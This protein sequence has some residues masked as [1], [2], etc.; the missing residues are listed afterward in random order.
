MTDTPLS[1]SEGGAP[2]EKPHPARQ[3]FAPIVLLGLLVLFHLLVNIW[4]LW[5]DNHVI[6]TDEETHMLTARDYYEVLALDEHESVLQLLIALG[7][8]QPRN[9]AHPPL[10]PIMGAALACVFGYGPDVFAFVNTIMFLL[11]ILGCYAVARC[12]LERWGAL[13]AAAVVSFVP[14]VF[15]ASRYFM[16]D[17]PATV[18]V[19]WSLYALLRSD[20]FS[21]RRWVIL[22]AVLNGLGILVRTVTFVYYLVPAAMLVF[23]GLVRALFRPPAGQTRCRA[24]AGLLGNCVATVLIS[25]AVFSPWYFHNLEPLYNFWVIEKPGAEGGPVTLVRESAPESKPQER[26]ADTPVSATAPG[27]SDI[28]AAAPAPKPIEKSGGSQFSYVKWFLHPRVPWVRYPVHVI[29]NNLFVILS[30]LAALGILLFPWVRNYRKLCVL[31]LLCCVLSSYVLMTLLIKYSV[32]RYALPVAPLLGILAALPFLSL[33]SRAV[34][35]AAMIALGVVLLLQFSN[36]TYASLGRLGNYHLPIILD[37]HTQNI[38]DDPGLTVIKDT[39]TYSNSYAELGAAM[40]NDYNPDDDEV[41]VRNCN[42]KERLFLAMVAAEHRRK[43]PVGAYANYIRLGQDMRGMELE[44]RYYWPLPNPFLKRGFPP[45]ELP[46]RKFT[47]IL[48][49][50]TP[51]W[52]LSKLSIADY[53]VYAIPVGQS[54]MER[55]W[56]KFFME[57]GFEPIERFTVRRFGLVYARTYCVMSRQ[58]G[59]VISVDSLDDLDA[60]NRYELYQLQTSVDFHRLPEPM[61]NYAKDR[62]KKLIEEANYPSAVAL[63]EYVT[64]LG[65]DLVRVEEGVFQFWF[66]FK[67]EKPIPEDWRIFLHGQVAPEHISLLPPEKQAQG[68]HDWNFNPDPRTSEWPAG[69]YVMITRSIRPAPIPYMFRIGFFNPENRDINLGSIMIGTVDFSRYSSPPSGTDH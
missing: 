47:C 54:D 6:R 22:F 49:A 56:Q 58:E 11:L 17:Y 5:A 9:P 69:E 29:N 64:Y 26:P 57:R 7:K 37:A 61:R 30:G 46:R 43:A 13:F 68:Y 38:Y 23:L 34:R 67:V 20:L 15:N 65:S 14:S 50:D 60:L 31:T 45:T 28:P 48:M 36:L 19:L 51:E 59:T 24:L 42:Y 16:T 40:R 33:R 4:F 41:S 1:I 39:L 52:A 3:S 63:N 27:Q 25:A 10:L 44:E 55:R 21:K 35:A 66:V 53:V 62:F 12:F 32:A 18:I 8:I 2:G